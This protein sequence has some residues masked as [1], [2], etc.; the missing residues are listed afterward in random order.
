MPRTQPITIVW[1]KQELDKAHNERLL[2]LKKIDEM[3]N[4][5]SSELETQIRRNRM[6]AV[7]LDRKN[8][9]VTPQSETTSIRN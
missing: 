5:I 9:D 2:I 6:L 1:L 3:E 8:P 7:K 4:F